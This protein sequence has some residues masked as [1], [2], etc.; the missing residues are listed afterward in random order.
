MRGC[1]PLCQRGAGVHGAL[2]RDGRGA[3]RELRGQV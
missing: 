2:P 1:Q 3:D